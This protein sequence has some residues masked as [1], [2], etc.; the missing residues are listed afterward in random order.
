MNMTTSKNEER[1]MSILEIARIMG[2]V[3]E[4]APGFSFDSD[5]KVKL[6]E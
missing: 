1:R 6:F 3:V 4:L 2:P 5:S